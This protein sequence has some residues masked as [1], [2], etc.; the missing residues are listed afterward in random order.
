M[1]LSIFPSFWSY[2]HGMTTLHCF[3]TE[4]GFNTGVLAHICVKWDESLSN[5]WFTCTSHLYTHTCLGN[6]WSKSN[7]SVSILVKIYSLLQLPSTDLTH[8]VDISPRKNSKG[9]SV[10]TLSFWQDPRPCSSLDILG[11][12]VFS[13]SKGKKIKTTKIWRSK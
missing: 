10:F 7:Y 3:Q 11:E 2:L 1:T 13:F 8:Y 12:L 4:G 6:C 9:S 5:I